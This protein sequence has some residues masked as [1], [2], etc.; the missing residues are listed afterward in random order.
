MGLSDRV[1]ASDCQEQWW[2][3]APETDGAVDA[4]L[5][6]LVHRLLIVDKSDSCICVTH[7]NLIKRLMLKFSAIDSTEQLGWELVQD[8]DRL[9]QR[10]KTKKLVNCGVLG[11]RFGREG[12]QWAVR[13]V[14]LM[15]DSK[16]EDDEPQESAVTEDAC[17]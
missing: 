13:D 1:D 8:S 12:Q 3:E 9:V 10:M 6:A 5:S 14:C 16:L 2:D 7:S 11:V 15:F 17:E 4:R